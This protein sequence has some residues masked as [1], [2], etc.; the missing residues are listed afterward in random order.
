[1]EN[2]ERLRQIMRI[3]AIKQWQCAEAAGLAET[4]V[5]RWLRHP[6]S[7]EHEAKIQSGI[8]AVLAM[9]QKALGG[10]RDDE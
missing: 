6:L 5:C 3:Y 1:M 10:V 9:R 7:A 4:T 2:N 8:D